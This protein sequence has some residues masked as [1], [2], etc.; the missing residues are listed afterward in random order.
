MSPTKEICI[1]EKVSLELIT[2]GDE[3]V[4]EIRWS[5]QD[6]F[7]NVVVENSLNDGGRQSTHKCIPRNACYTFKIHDSIVNNVIQ[8]DNQRGLYTIKLDGVT[9]SSG[10]NFGTDHHVMFGDSC[11]VNGNAVCS[12]NDPDES[13]MFRLEFVGDNFGDDITWKLIDSKERIVR[14][15]G[16]FGDCNVNSLAACVPRA[17]CYQFIAINN[18][19][20]SPESVGLFTVLFSEVDDIIQNYTGYFSRGT[21]QVFLGSCYDMNFMFNPIQN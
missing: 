14:D 11:L 8:S 6:L 3:F 13:S 1:A 4:N 18:A 20:D 5:V 17:D 9:V 19:S 7:G 12:A 21:S 16:P 15:A 10:S 2:E